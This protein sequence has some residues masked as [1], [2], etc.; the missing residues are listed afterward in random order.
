MFWKDTIE[1]T[2]R[3]AIQ[4]AAAAVLALW[5]Q[6]G[7]FSEIDWSAMWQV[8]L[9]AAGFTVL[10]ALATKNAGANNDSPSIL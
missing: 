6:A 7:S 2:V 3:T 9:F 10:S 1:R 8:A 5:V 4:A